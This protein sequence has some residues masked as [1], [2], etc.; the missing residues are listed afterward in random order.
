MLDDPTQTRIS[1]NMV[2]ASRR[3][4]GYE[5]TDHSYGQKVKSK[6]AT[7]GLLVLPIYKIQ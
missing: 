3:Y 7:T 1:I 2:S 6:V 5:R 4:H